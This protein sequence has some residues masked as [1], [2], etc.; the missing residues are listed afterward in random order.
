[1]ELAQLRE[2]SHLPLGLLPAQTPRCREVCRLILLKYIVKD[3]SWPL[4]VGLEF[5]ENPK[6]SRGEK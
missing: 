4:A 5:F 3:V 1:M 2:S 6:F